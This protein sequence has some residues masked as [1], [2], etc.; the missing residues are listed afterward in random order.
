M[1]NV[2]TVLLLVFCLTSFNL[3]AKSETDEKCSV[4]KIENFEN[5]FRYHN[6]YLSGQPGIEQLQWLKSEGVTRIINLRTSGENEE[7]A[8]NDFDEKSKAEEMGFE[9]IHIPVDGYDDYHPE[10]LEA[11]SEKLNT[12]EKVL[13]HCRSAGRVTYFF[14][15]Y[16][17]KSKGFNLEEAVEIGEQLKYSNPLERL[18]NVEITLKPAGSVSKQ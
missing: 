7:F 10:K 14:M 16:L 2:V 4:E 1:K 9:Y 15:A 11:V 5:V 13:L 6:F 12:N 18:L 3:F 17:V 8:E